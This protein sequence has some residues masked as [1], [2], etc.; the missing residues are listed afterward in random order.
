MTT[1]VRASKYR[2]L[3]GTPF[4]LRDCY[5]DICIGQCSTESTVLKAND[6][7]FALP[8]A[9]KGSICI[10]PLPRVGTVPEDTPLI[11]NINED[12]ERTAINEFE[13]SPHDNQLL[14]AAGQDGG[15]AAFRIPGAEGLTANV[16]QAVVRIQASDKRLLSV[17]WHPL[18]SGVVYTAS[19]NKKISFF[20]LEAGSELFTLPEVHKGLFTNGS[21]N[22]DGSLF[23]TCCK[24]KKLRIFD[25]RSSSMVAETDSHQSAKSSHV[26]WMGNADVICTAGFT[27]TSEREL[28]SFDPRNMSARMHTEKLSSSSSAVMMFSDEDCNLLFLAGKGDS[29]I[30]YFEVTSDAPGVHLLSEY[31]SNTPQNGLA[32]LPKTA[33]N[34]NKCELARFLKLSGTR[35]E[36]IRFEVPRQQSDN[37]F[38]DDLYPPTSDRKATMTAGEWQSGANT[39]QGTI[40]MEQFYQ[41]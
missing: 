30:T 41:A 27:R 7:F 19:A 23:T 8:W 40:D 20:D 16:D 33:C 18:A 22:K 10:T 3:F 14:A 9:D 34:V 21:W 4:Q 37:F 32:L 24:D 6:Q 11:L 1:R 15:L 5:G 38:Q 29:S 13:F 31:K 12:Q 25:P 35:V 17:G 26:M 36:P 39:P 2:H 28:A